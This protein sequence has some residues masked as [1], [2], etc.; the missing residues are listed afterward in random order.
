MKIHCVGAGP[1][2]TY[3]SILLKAARPQDEITVF[4]RHRPHDAEGWGVVFSGRTCEDLAQAD[5]GTWSA[6]TRELVAWDTIEVH[7]RGERVRTSGHAFCGVAR[8]RFTTLL[9]ERARTLGVALRFET[10]VDDPELLRDCDLLVGADGF[11]S[12][13]RSRWE[14]A[15]APSHEAGEC[16]YIWLGTRKLF[17]TF[18]FAFRESA[19]GVFQVHAYPFSRETSTFI[20]ECHESTWRRAGLDRAGEAY[21]AAYCAELFSDLLDGHPLLSNRSHWI[22][23][24]TLRCARW[25]HENVA[26]VGDAAHTAHFSIGSGTKLALED[27]TALARAVAGASSIREALAA[28]EAERMP[29]VGRMQEAAG[30]SRGWFE[31]T[32][33][34]M[35][36][37]AS[38]L[39][40]SLMGRVPK[41][42]RD[43]L[44]A[45]DESFVGRVEREFARAYG[46]S[47]GTDP[48][49]VPFRIG[50][51]RLDG[52]IARNG[53]GGDDAA[54]RFLAVSAAVPE[55]I[56]SVAMVDRAAHD[57]PGRV[58]AL[59][60]RARAEGF[61]AVELWADPERDQGPQAELFAA[62]RDVFGGPVI[63]RLDGNG[64]VPLA[65]TLARAGTAALHVPERD[66]ETHRLETDLPVIAIA[67]DVTDDEV[68]T[69]L[70]AGRADVVDRG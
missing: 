44:A 59:V 31:T 58:L 20:V 47:E 60:R 17:D 8:D 50:A 40:F 48:A 36:L 35:K 43:A 33:R 41:L 19:H 38:E 45:R 51:M 70:L 21:S 46:A 29:R 69:A 18:T 24:D 28:Y 10:P 9:H 25:T 7:A 54:L 13:C 42:G 61:H 27:A 49:K 14:P 62:A 23:F 12:A 16:R 57:D 55:T 37:S 2:G 56:P 39:A 52:R 34:R 6:V 26:L 11:G 5:P 66:A 65:R 63:A 30:H 53:S 22:R 15:F 32:D 64:G 4:E 68:T 3:F 67:P 1:A